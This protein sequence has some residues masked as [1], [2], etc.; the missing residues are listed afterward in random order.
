[1]TGARRKML[2]A[3]L[4]ATSVLFDDTWPAYHMT[5]WDSSRGLCR[6]SSYAR[7]LV[8]IRLVTFLD[9]CERVPICR[10]S[11]AGTNSCR[12][13]VP[14]WQCEHALGLCQ[15][16]II[17]KSTVAQLGRMPDTSSREPGIESPLLL[18]RRL[19]IFVIS[20]TPQFTQLYKRVPFYRQWRKYV[21]EWSSRSNC[22]VAECFP[23]KSSWYRNEQVCQGVKCKALWLVRRTRYFAI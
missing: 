20:T 6:Q 11:C 13:T 15:L 17:D 18:L 1:M 16:M 19:D 10:Q 22:S 21:S 23:E 8:S 5:V 9:W 3:K 4:Y 7:M 2:H 14:E 12:I